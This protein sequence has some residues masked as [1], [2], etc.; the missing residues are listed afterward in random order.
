VIDGNPFK[1]LHD[2]HD[3]VGELLEVLGGVGDEDP[4]W[5]AV[6]DVQVSLLS[7]GTVS[8]HRGRRAHLVAS[9]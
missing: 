7:I 6:H 1:P 2:V 4:K 8:R 5:W 9:C 3:N